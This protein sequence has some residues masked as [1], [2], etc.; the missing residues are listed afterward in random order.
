MSPG[1]GPHGPGRRGVSPWRLDGAPAPLPSGE[2]Q[3][4]GVRRDPDPGRAEGE[5]LSFPEPPPRKPAPKPGP[6]SASHLR[7]P[8]RLP[9][10][11]PTLQALV[12]PPSPCPPAG[13]TPP[14]ALRLRR[15]CAL[16]PSG[17]FPVARAL[18][19]QSAVVCAQTRWKLGLGR[20]VVR[21]WRRGTAGKPQQK[22]G[23]LAPP[24]QPRTRRRLT[25]GSPQDSES[26]PPPGT[27]HPAP[28]VAAS[29]LMRSCL[30]AAPE[31][32][33]DPRAETLGNAGLG[34]LLAAAARGTR[35]VLPP[36][37][38]RGADAGSARGPG[39]QA[40]IS[41]LARMAALRPIRLFI[42]NDASGGKKENL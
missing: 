36:E 31:L 16:A 27:T 42:N 15:P 21:T 30:P 1:P 10:R 18:L 38:A 6:S 12:A 14:G 33:P 3:E 2:R 8:G 13:P 19:D 23:P 9:T 7:S 17:V 39:L 29:P 32:G 34:R 5:G 40:R 25:R 37:G 24:T 26:P 35:T 41:S 4:P 20:A 11:A 22:I 28:T